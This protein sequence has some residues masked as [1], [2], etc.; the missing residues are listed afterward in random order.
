VLKILKISFDFTSGEHPKR[1]PKNQISYPS[2]RY[3]MNWYREKIRKKKEAQESKTPKH[4]KIKA[5]LTNS[6]EI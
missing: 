3:C 2:Q 1:N 4:K 6:L 5:V